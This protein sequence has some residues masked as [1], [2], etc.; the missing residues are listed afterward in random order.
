MAANSMNDWFLFFVPACGLVFLVTGAFMLLVGV[1]ATRAGRSDWTA[2]PTEDEVAV[3]AQRLRCSFAW[4]R[5]FE[6]VG[7]PFW[8]LVG[9]LTLWFSQWRAPYILPAVGLFW[10]LDRK[11]GV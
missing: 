11:N 9:L 4:T 7:G 3:M 1:V 10:V 5:R 6:R 8:F 2:A